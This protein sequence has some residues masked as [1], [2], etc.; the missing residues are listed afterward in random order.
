MIDAEGIRD[1]THEQYVY[2]RYAGR[3]W[4]WYDPILARMRAKAIVLDVGSGLGLFVECCMHHGLAAVGME[5]SEEGVSASRARGVP[6]VRADVAVQFPFRDDS[7]GSA[8]AHHVLEHVP[9]E[10]ERSVLRE[11]RRVL[12]PGGFLMVVSPNLHHPHARD[13]PDH[14][15]LFTPHRLARELSAAG[16]RRVSLATNYWYPYWDPG[17]RLGI[18]GS[19]LTGTLWKVAPIDRFSATASAIAWK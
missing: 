4:R 1:H 13:D 7:F 10:T 18:V 15:N 17:N 16:F 19:L 9:L 11:I 8:L 5:L 14:R 6:V 12:R 3:D 2:W